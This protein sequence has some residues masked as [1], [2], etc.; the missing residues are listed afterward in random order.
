VI[1]EELKCRAKDYLEKREAQELDHTDPDL[2]YARSE[3]HESLMM[4]MRIDGISFSDREHAAEIA[5]AIVS[6]CS[7]SEVTDQDIEGV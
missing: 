5:R 6:G 2:N 7:L 1:S 3:A 4:Q